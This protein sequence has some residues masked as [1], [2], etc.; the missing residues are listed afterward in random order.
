MTEIHT[1]KLDVVVPL[2]NDEEV[3]ESLCETV[4]TR[5]KTNS[6]RFE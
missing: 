2:Y 4:S 6:N 3:I 5:C 1:Y